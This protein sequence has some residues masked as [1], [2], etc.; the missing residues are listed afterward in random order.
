MN[1]TQALAELKREKANLCRLYQA[2]YDGF[3]VLENEKAEI[4]F[5]ETTTQ[6]N[7][8]C[9]Q[10]DDLKTKISV[11]NATTMIEGKPLFWYIV[12]QGTVRSELDWLGQLIE[13][14]GRKQHSEYGS[15][16]GS[17]SNSQVDRLTL[18]AKIAELEKEKGRLD[19][20]IQSANFKT[21][22]D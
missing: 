22:L 7:A 9:E 18:N 3:R 10:I 6:I 16:V 13:R 8:S 20:V 19:S 15:N 12:R 4:P 2:R 17:T 5:V 11:A 14:T 21:K 1:I